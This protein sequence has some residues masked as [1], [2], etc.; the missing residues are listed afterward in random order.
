MKKFWKKIVDFVQVIAEN[1]IWNMRRDM[2]VRANQTF[3]NLDKIYYFSKI[4]SLKY[5]NG[6]MKNILTSLSWKKMF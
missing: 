4:S 2:K 3:N 5:N 6:P 1:A